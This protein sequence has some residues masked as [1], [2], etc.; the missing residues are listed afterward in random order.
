MIRPDA[1]MRPAIPAFLQGPQLLPPPGSLS[2]Q[3]P[4][5]ALPPPAPNATPDVFPAPQRR[6]DQVPSAP[7]PAP[8]PLGSADEPLPRPQQGVRTL[9]QG[10]TG[11]S[12]LA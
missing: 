12:R 5:A 3:P 10:P 11:S 8:T 1:E 9:G 2:M 4:S 7:Q 6:S